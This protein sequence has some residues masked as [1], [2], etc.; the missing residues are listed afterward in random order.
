MNLV[1]DDPT[2]VTETTYI[3][4][5]TYDD[6]LVTDNDEH[7]CGKKIIYVAHGEVTVT[8]VGDVSPNHVPEIAV[9]VSIRNEGDR[10]TARV[11]LASV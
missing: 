7:W 5:S 2:V 10:R 11:P 9:V 3:H 4:L 6:S 8:S 1:T